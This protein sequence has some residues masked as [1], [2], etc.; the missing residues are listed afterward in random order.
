[1]LFLRRKRWWPVFAGIAFGCVELFSFIFS[2]K[3]LGVTRAYTVTGAIISY[4]ISP[5]HVE[6]VSYWKVYAPVLDWANALV[7]G[8]VI[9]GLISSWLSGDFKVKGVPELWKASHGNSVAARWI[10]AFVAGIM[11]GFAARL[12]GG[13][14]SG[15]LISACIQLAP[16]GYVFMMSLYIGA[17]LTTAVFYRGKG[18]SLR[19]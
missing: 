8:L 17:V 3:P 10:W 16:G 2:E 7:L 4:L 6:K 15:L 5:A 14:V 13:C 12:T 1:M 18:F 19:R 11:M 9:G